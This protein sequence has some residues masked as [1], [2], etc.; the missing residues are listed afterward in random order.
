MFPCLKIAA[1]PQYAW[2]LLFLRPEGHKYV[3]CLHKGCA[4]CEN[5][6]HFSLKL[7]MTT[8]GV[9]CAALCLAEDEVLRRHTLTDYQNIQQ[10]SLVYNTVR[11]SR[12]SFY[13]QDAIVNRSLLWYW[14]SKRTFSSI[15]YTVDSKLYTEGNFKPRG[16]CYTCSSCMAKNFNTVI[17]LN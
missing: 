16:R 12:T 1:H 3:Y 11:G 17:V 7:R 15:I 4:E 14:S 8:C 6:N 2:Q 13:P 10:R 5:D 9:L